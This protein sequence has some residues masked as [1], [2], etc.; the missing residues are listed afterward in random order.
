MKDIRNENLCVAGEDI[1]KNNAV[2]FKDGKVYNLSSEEYSAI[3]DE[4]QI[5][6]E[7]C[8]YCDLNYM[9]NVLEVIRDVV[10]HKQEQTIRA[11]RMNQVHYRRICT[12]EFCQ[13]E[14]VEYNRK[15]KEQRIAEEEYR[16][17]NNL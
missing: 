2:T 10:R 8:D 13:C 5:V 3:I 14:M 15:V 16:I 7:L 4:E 11:M 6:D 17:K 12:P 1:K 9:D